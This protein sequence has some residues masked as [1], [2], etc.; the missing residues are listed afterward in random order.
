MNALKKN[1]LFL[2]MS[3]G[4]WMRGKKKRCKNVFPFFLKK[5]LFVALICLLDEFLYRGRKNIRRFDSC[6]RI[7]T[8]FGP[9]RM[10]KKNHFILMSWIVRIINGVGLRPGGRGSISPRS[11]W[12]FEEEKK[13][14]SLT[15][16]CKKLSFHL[17]DLLKSVWPKMNHRCISFRC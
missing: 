9:E 5:K 17:T 7:I 16:Q 3:T 14:H 1:F 8:W 15:F 10:I 12:Y 2:N 4:S 13:Q 6:R 11:E